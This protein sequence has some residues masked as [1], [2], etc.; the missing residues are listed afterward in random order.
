MRLP[1]PDQYDSFAAAY[2]DHASDGPY[3]ALYD[4]PAT[5][6][7]L[8]DVAG[9]RLL[10]A[11]CGPGFYV[12]ELLARGAEVVACDASAAMVDLARQRC[13]DGLDARVHSLDEPLTWLADA[14]VDT[15][16][17]ALAYHYVSN[18]AGFLAEVRRVLRPGGR[19]VIS[20]HHPV[21]D[22]VRHGGSYFEVGTLTEVWSKGWEITTW[23]MPLTR[24]TEE[25]A[26]AG[27]LIERLVEPLPHPDMGRSHP[28]VHAKLTNRPG[29]ILFQLRPA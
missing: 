11:G 3:N 2:E 28:E 26:T 15:V 1:E 21:D 6:D 14:S 20:T 16:L 29:F 12:A 5:L 19:L 22:W 9:T 7:L 8:G 10:D 4:R 27:F 23:R 13:G 24:L 17:C 25:F 18:R